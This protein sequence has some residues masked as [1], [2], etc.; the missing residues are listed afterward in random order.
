MAMCFWSAGRVQAGAT[1][2]A[3]RIETLTG[4]NL[5]VD[6]NAGTPASYAP[7]SA[8]L[9]VTFYNDGSVPLTDVI[10]RIGDY[11]GGVGD[12]PGIYPTNT[13]PIL[14]GPLPGGAFA[15]THEGGSSGLAD[16]T[17]YIAEIPAG[18]SVTVYWLVSYPQVDIYNVPTWGTSVKPDDDLWLQYDVWATATEGA[19]ARNVDIT[20]TVTLRNEISAA[21]N[22]IF[23]N[24]ANKVPDYYKELM[25]QFV[26]SWTNANA[27][28]SVG[29]RIITEG[30]WYDLGNVGEGFDNNGDLVPDHNAWMQPVGDPSRFDASAFRLVR[31]YAMVIVK[32]RDGSDL[33]LTG[34]NQLYFENIPE[35]N[36]AVGYVLYEFLPMLAGAQSMTTP[37]QEVASGRDNEKFNA[38]YGVALGGMLVSGEAKVL[39]DKTA[40][41]TN[42]APGGTITYK[43]AYTNAGVAS[44]G[45]P[46]AGVPLVVQDA[47]P[48]GTVFVA[49]SASVSNTLPAGVSSYHVLYSADGGATWSATQPTNAAS[50]TH[51][52][53]W[54]DDPLLAGAAGAISFTV[55]VDN[56]FTQPAPLVDNT[57]GLSLGNNKPFVTDEEKTWVT[58]NNVLGDTVYADTG[59]G[60]GGY[61]GN[62][63]QDGSEAGI[64]NI[65]VRLYAD[66][67]TNGVLD[68]GEPLVGTAQTATNGTYLFTSLAD[69]RYVAVVD[70]Q[71]SDLPYGYTLTTPGYVAADLD[72]GRLTT[73]AVSFL[74]ADYGFAPA[75]VLS[76]ARAGAGTLYEG[77]NVTYTLAVTNRL[78]GDGSGAA[79]PTKYRL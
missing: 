9:G 77:Q 49:G 30:I 56:P 62:G 6:S 50:V 57:A 41:V 2:G 27:D 32:L 25:S 24:G 64:S 38:D 44:V 76:K 26:P 28:G 53:W 8:Y 67:N 61:F 31:T 72:S 69:G 11:K 52:Q 5:V 18:G 16:A 36:G 48:T 29:T 51:I 79:K 71:D 21:A 55:T 39:I 58:G 13:S 23:P 43:V 59:T 22:K 7:Y 12:T 37:Y 33:I 1:D 3:L 60:T 10:A 17:R 20:R 47:V 45:D 68:A 75:L 54:L 4:Y 78:S 65:T 14:T 34:E 15:L 46:A 19:A 63:I 42:V 40:N 73:N 74:A 70:A 35:N 66:L